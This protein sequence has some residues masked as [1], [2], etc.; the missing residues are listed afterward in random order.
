MNRGNKRD[1]GQDE[2]TLAEGGFGKVRER[3]QSVTR[4]RLRPR[5][6]KTVKEGVVVGETERE[7]KTI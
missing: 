3:V 7:Y 1:T 5:N 4:G 2:A 6:P